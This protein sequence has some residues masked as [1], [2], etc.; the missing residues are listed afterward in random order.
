M[1]CRRGGEGVPLRTRCKT[2]SKILDLGSRT[3][4]SIRRKQVGAFRLSRQA[5]T[6]G[7]LKTLL[8]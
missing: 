6:G 2:I 5:D 3:N 1:P 4:T 7:S 8:S